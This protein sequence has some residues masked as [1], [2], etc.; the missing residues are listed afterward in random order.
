MDN[1]LPGPEWLDPNLSSQDI[2]YGMD[3]EI[4]ESPAYKPHIVAALTSIPS[5]SLVIDL[6]SLF[7][8]DSGIY[9]NAL[10]HGVEWERSASLELI[11]PDGSEGFQ[12]NC[13]VRI[14]GGWSRH[15]GCP[16]RAFRFFF[17]NEYGEGKLRYPLFGE[18]GVDEFD[19]IDLRTAMN[20]SWSYS[21]D[22]SKNT[23]VRDAFS[24]DTQRDM[25]QPYTRSRYYHLYINGTY[26]GLYQTQE[27]SEASFAEQY[28]G[29]SREDYDVVKVN[30]GE[31]F[32]Q[33]HV[34]A[35]DGTL[36]AWKRLWD[37][38]QAG[39]VSDE[40]Y[41][42]VQGYNMNGSINPAYEKL[43]D[44]DN[45]I[46]YMIVTF[47]VGDFDGPISN[48]R[49]NYSPNNFYTI[50]NRVNPDGFK[51]FRHDA[52][53]SM[54]F[55]EW[56]EDR[57]GPFPAGQNFLDSN[58]QWIHQKL[59]ENANYRL[60]F[61]DRA[62][63]HLFLDGELTLEK[64]RERIS[65]RKD[66]IEFAIIAE[67]A[68]WGDSK[69]S[70]PYTYADWNSAVNFITNS[71]L[72]NRNGILINQLIEKGLL[73]PVNPPVFSQYGG[74]VD[75]GFQV[76][77]LNSIGETYYTTDSSDP[78]IPFDADN[79]AYS[80]D[81]VVEER[82]KKVFVPRSSYNENWQSL[83]FDDNSWL[84][85]TGAPG[86]IGYEM[87]FGYES[88]VTLSTQQYM[89]TSG[90]NPNTSC[91]IRIPFEVS[92]ENLSEF[93][94]MNLS[95]LYDDGFV[96]YI[97]GQK[98]EDE[99]APASIAWN[100]AATENHEA[101]EYVTFDLSGHIN[102]LQ[103][104]T[105]ILAIQGLNV[106]LSSSDFLILP[107]LTAGKAA[108]TGSISESAIRYTDPFPINETATISARVL[109]AAQWSPLTEAL[110]IIDEDL[111]DLRITE[112][113]YHP[114]D[115]D[116]INDGEF[117]FTE[118]K[119][120]G[121]S[122]L[123]LTASSFVRG[124]DFVFPSGSVLSPGEFIVLASDSIQ[125]N[126]RY[127]FKPFGEYNGQLNNGGE[128]VSLINAAGDTVISFEYSDDVP[129]PVEADGDGY[130]LVASYR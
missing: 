80:L 105:N 56:G 79:S 65:S 106:S 121:N 13:G 44:V 95:M 88:L 36:D 38:A 20:Y 30:T 122:D 83:N 2:N 35:T 3:P 5:M 24:R 31:N 115:H 111:S 86:G 116:T 82:S 61:A 21:G 45:L 57:T 127:G 6:K 49:G 84:D 14:R 90:S 89:H 9:V 128:T 51:F 15:D 100:S 114:L 77:F 52:E 17:K 46:D 85:C 12:I 48:F 66:Q 81:L 50:Y 34:E 92:E 76:S 11:Y 19:K 126:N 112:L 103:T 113:H 110:F 93:N 29:G 97:N 1:Q 40:A 123:N 108:Q 54:F 104:G 28:F 27:R 72:S 23:F 18:E 129:W 69:T 96:A 63:R 75:K 73:P 59:S 118:L 16:K 43:L 4:Y 101:D 7:D 10:K 22:G 102:K 70:N 91:L 125:F 117:E 98:V 32:D 64:N 42:K 94:F 78:Y 119:N 107:K 74:E 67:S 87:D 60:R 71:F 25:E 120:I 41:F 68:R 53:H 62:Y 8:P 99:L 33:Y 26:W 124:I 47:F 130:S 37:A 58:P 39:F 55:H 109:Q